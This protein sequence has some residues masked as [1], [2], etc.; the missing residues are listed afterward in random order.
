[1]N[2]LLKLPALDVA[3]TEQK[4]FQSVDEAVGYVRGWNEVIADRLETVRQALLEDEGR[5]L[6]VAS[7]SDAIPLLEH[8]SRFREPMLG[9]T[10]EG[11]LSAFWSERDG[12]ASLNLKFLGDGQIRYAAKCGDLDHNYGGISVN[13][14]A[15]LFPWYLDDERGSEWRT[16]ESLPTITYL[17]SF[18]AET[19]T[20]ERAEYYLEP[21]GFEFR[22]V[23]EKIT[24]QRIVWSVS[25]P[26][27]TPKRSSE[28]GR[29]SPSTPAVAC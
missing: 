26:R 20:R 19:M 23:S 25:A 29:F 21:S 9:L 27:A 28:L 4:S 7:L 18:L 10:D 14:A 13:P 8:L 5:D 3:A 22:R 16:T 15:S 24:H 1:M 6:D 17:G 2:S 11:Q 12:H